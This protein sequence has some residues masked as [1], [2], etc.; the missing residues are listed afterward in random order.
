M[1]RVSP[2]TMGRPFATKPEK[3]TSARTSGSMRDDLFRESDGVSIVDADPPA[4]GASESRESIV[5]R[6]ASLWRSASVQIG[7]AGPIRAAES[8]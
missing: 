5:A 8:A 7:R 3:T 2:E 1:A 6:I 4:R